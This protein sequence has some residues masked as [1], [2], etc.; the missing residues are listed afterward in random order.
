MINRANIKPRKTAETSPKQNTY[1]KNAD[2]M[3]THPRCDIHVAPTRD[4]AV[5][6]WLRYNIQGVVTDKT[7]TDNVQ[8]STSLCRAGTH[9]HY[10]HIDGLTMPRPPYERSLR[11]RHRKEFAKVVQCGV[12]RSVNVA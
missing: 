12:T 4:G 1:L 6:L 3:F 9:H 8:V 10:G 7:D 5:D 11:S 2:R